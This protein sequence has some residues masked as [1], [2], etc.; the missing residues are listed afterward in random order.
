MGVTATSNP[1]EAATSAERHEVVVIGAGGSGMSVA[2]LL[3]RACVDAV[4]LEGSA[5]GASWRSRYERLHLH[6]HRLV[7]GYPGL[8]PACTL[9]AW[10]PPP[11]SSVLSLCSPEMV[12]NSSSIEVT[13]PL[14]TGAN[15]ERGP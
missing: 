15:R 7:S 6:T 9:G 4:A 14:S 1:P 13:I 2:A 8:A 11:L 3:A 12:R 10:I 5:V